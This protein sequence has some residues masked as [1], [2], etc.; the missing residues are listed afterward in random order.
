M[1]NT[2]EPIGTFGNWITG[3][4]A[5]GGAIS[6][7]ADVQILAACGV[8]HVIDCRAEFDDGHLLASGGFFYLY[9]PTADDGTTKPASWFGR[10]LAFAL[11]ALAHRH[12]RVYAH[13]AAGVNR[14][15]STAYAVLRALGLTPSDAMSL[16]KSGRPQALVRYAADAD[17]AI[18][19]LGY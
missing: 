1:P 5:T 8:T 18:P 15:P 3:R 11:P 9:N 14:G 10:S 16:V 6:S 7:T 4:L 19:N 2:G 13:C 12:H 17:L